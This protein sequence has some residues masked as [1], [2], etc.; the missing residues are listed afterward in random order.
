MH[1]IFCV[2][3]EMAVCGETLPLGCEQALSN[4][5]T[6]AEL[7]RTALW[8]I[9]E[10][11]RQRDKQTTTGEK[12]KEKQFL[13]MCFKGKELEI[14]NNYR[15]CIRGSP[16]ENQFDAIPSVSSHPRPII[17]SSTRERTKAPLQTTATAWRWG[18]QM[19]YQ[20]SAS[21]T[22]PPFAL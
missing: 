18:S 3:T 1:F 7:A 22:T 20:V 6:S 13:K 8:N 19:L 9:S 11:S 14:Q 12:K 15:E 5:N 21:W 4:S 10:T 2:F 16:R 17:N